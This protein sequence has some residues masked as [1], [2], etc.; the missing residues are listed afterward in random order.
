M[1]TLRPLPELER[2]EPFYEREDFERFV[3][4]WPELAGVQDQRARDRW[5]LDLMLGWWQ[6]DFEFLRKTFW[7][8]DKNS[9]KVLLEPNYVQER[10]YKDVVMRCQEEGVPIRGI[11]LK[12]RQLGMST[13]I[14]ALFYTWCMRQQYRHSMTIN[15]DDPSTEVL[16]SKMR[17]AQDAFWFPRPIQQRRSHSLHFAEPHGSRHEGVTA[18]KFAAGRSYTLHFVHG[19]EPPYWP[20]A[21][22]LMIGIQDSVPFEPFTAI[23]LESTAQ[24]ASGYFYDSWQKAED[25][26]SGYVPFFAPWFWDPAYKIDFIS[27]DHLRRFMRSLG[28]E[29]IEYMKRHQLSPEQMRWRDGKIR[30]KSR[31]LF[32]QEFPASPEE[33][34]L[35]SGS[36]VFDLKKVLE[37]ERRCVPPFFRG[38]ILLEHG[39]DPSTVP[40]GTLADLG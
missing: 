14:Q 23:F 24:G 7:I 32:Q 16:F 39:P 35:S 28:G 33:A 38:E 19:S 4:W 3:K 27:S 40:G 2:L 22:R 34:F 12:A 1:A 9:R 5:G 10:F 30:E 31:T 36:P 25:G 15:Y 6:D 18:G 13:F 37:L 11:V 21:E 29:D 26:W 8:Q 20:D 17:Y